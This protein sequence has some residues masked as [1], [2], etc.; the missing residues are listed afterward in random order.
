[1]AWRVLRS[2]KKSAHTLMEI[3]RDLLQNLK[4]S[5]PPLLHLYEWQHPSATMGLFIDPNKFLNLNE[6][7]K[8]GVELAKRPT[9]GGI[10][11]HLSDLAFS[12][13]VPAGHPAFSLNPLA[14]YAFVNEKVKK[15]I[16]RFAPQTADLLE[17]ENEKVS[18]SCERFCMAHPTKYD[19]MVGGKKVGGAAQRKT[20]EGYLHQGSIFIAPLPEAFLN[21]VLL[22]A[23]LVAHAMKEN[24]FPLLQPEWT[25]QEL[26]SVRKSLCALLIEEF[27][28]V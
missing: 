20:R 1:M 2:G 5:D 6:L 22:E 23:P 26:E 12:V 25:K 9:G 4:P 24:S 27:T 18:P 3:D 19:V 15:V 17:E 28:N 13:L 21:A 16:Q 14:N 7:S 11:F 10:V 8:N